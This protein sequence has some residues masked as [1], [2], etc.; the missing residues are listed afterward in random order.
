MY[1]DTRTASPAWTSF[2]QG[3]F[4]SGMSAAYVVKGVAT[5]PT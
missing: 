2:R 3:E 5:A 1:L 4:K